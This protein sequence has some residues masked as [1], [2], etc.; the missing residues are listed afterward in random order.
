MMSV[1]PEPDTEPEAGNFTSEQHPL[2]LFFDGECA[3]CNRWVAR[4]KDADH[5]HRIRFGTKQG[6]TFQVVLKRH[7]E[8]AN[9]DSVVLA[10][11]KPDGGEDF[12]VRSRAIRELIDGLAPFRFFE[13]VLT[14]CPTPLSDLGYMIFS[15]LRTPLFGKWHNC[16]VP[17]E[18]DKVLFVD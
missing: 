9:V 14:I 11:R 18:Q 12:L 3:F 7:P 16:R 2:L 15:K 6:Q 13:L 17:I 1:L 8:V 4:V 10:V 5:R